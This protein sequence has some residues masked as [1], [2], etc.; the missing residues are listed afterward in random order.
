MISRVSLNF[1]RYFT[2]TSSNCIFGGWLNLVEELA[3]R[4]H[5]DDLN[6]RLFSD[7]EFAMVFSVLLKRFTTLNYRSK[8]FKIHTACRFTA[9]QKTDRLMNFNEV[10]GD[11]GCYHTCL[12]SNASHERRMTKELLHLREETNLRCSQVVTWGL[13]LVLFR[14]RMSWTDDAVESNVEI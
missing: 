7:E 3:R 13:Q 14:N 11:N 6:D 1:W 5:W 4:F 12:Q 9:T 2:S 8:M 10:Q